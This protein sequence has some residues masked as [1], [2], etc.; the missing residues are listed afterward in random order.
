M[1]KGVALIRHVAVFRFK[2]EFDADQREAWMEMIRALP[3]SIPEI[4]SLS[5][6][7]DVLRGPH[8][9]DIGLVADFDSLEAMDAYN[10]HPEHQ[11]VLA[12]SGP[13]KEHLAVADF[14]V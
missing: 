12:V 4:R 6:G 9:Y 13:V 14:E 2:P 11:K 8:S 1:T 5:I 3:D 10:R 7:S